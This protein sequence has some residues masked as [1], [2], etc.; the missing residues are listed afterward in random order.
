MNKTERPLVGQYEYVDLDDVLRW[1]T[2]ERFDKSSLMRIEQLK[3]LRE[4]YVET[5]NELGVYSV[6][7]YIKSNVGIRRLAEDIPN[8]WE[9]FKGQQAKFQQG[10]FLGWANSSNYDPS[11][12]GVFYYTVGEKPSS[13]K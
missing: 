3:G 9:T 1:V 8:Y 12:Q 11:L 6:E 5:K 4:Y 2:S 7:G 13:A 10:K